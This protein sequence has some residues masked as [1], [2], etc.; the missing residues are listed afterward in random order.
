MKLSSLAFENGQPIPKKHTEDGADESPPLAWID[1]PKGAVELALIVDDPDAPRDDPF[2]HW[3]AYHIPPTIESLPPALPVDGVLMDPPGV[4]QGVNSFGENVLGYRGPAPP[5]GHGVHRYH[6][7]LYALDAPLELEPGVDKYTLVSR[8][9][10]HVID[11][12]ELVG[13]YER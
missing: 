2:V 12:A 6:F 9:E 8:M 10:G 11:Q 7:K 4:T 1:V 13:V 3:L 5:K